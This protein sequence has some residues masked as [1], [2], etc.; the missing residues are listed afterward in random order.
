MSSEE[1]K[2]HIRFIAACE[3]ASATMRNV[4]MLVSAY[5]TA[6]VESGLSRDEALS[7]AKSYQDFIFSM[8]NIDDI[9]EK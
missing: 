2:K 6:L 8:I 4:A 7:L 3:Q 9:K 1:Q 5:F